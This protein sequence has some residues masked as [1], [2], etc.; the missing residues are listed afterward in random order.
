MLT[1]INSGSDELLQLILVGQP[2]LKA[3]LTSPDMRQFAQR[4]SVYFDLSALDPKAAVKYIR[5][6]LRQ[7]GGSGNEF[8]AEAIRRV[9]E[10]TGGIPRVMNKLCD[11]SLVYAASAGSQ[12]VSEAVVNDVL[13]DGLLIEFGSPV[14]LPPPGAHRDAAE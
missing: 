8:E 10:E 3:L 2:Q 7:A 13:N 12:T 6:R 4:V 1:N 14:L 9:Y 5:H 11:L